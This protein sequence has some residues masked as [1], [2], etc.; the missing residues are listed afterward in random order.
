MWDGGS[1]SRFPGTTSLILADSYL[2]R[3]EQAV[4]E[5]DLVRARAAINKILDLQKQHELGLPDEFH[6][7]Y[8]K[9]ADS[10]DLPEQA[11]ESVVRYLAVAGREGRHYVEAL[12]LMNK[13]QDALQGRKG[14]Q[15]AS[16]G[17]PPPTQPSIDFGDDSSALSSQDGVAVS[18]EEC[19][20]DEYFRTATVVDV[21]ACLEAGADSMARD[22]LKKTPLH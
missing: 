4:R 17:Q 22:V 21:R 8:A 3:A 10:A 18:C 14:Q 6:F 7:R 12:E 13:A 9:A 20:T 15:V 5:G 2:L 11:L 16:L 1:A 19:N